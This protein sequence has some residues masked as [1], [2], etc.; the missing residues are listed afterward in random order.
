[1]NLLYLYI[2]IRIYVSIFELMKCLN[3]NQTTGI[4]T[5]KKKKN[6][7]ALAFR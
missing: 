3:K 7:K 1:M 2:N 4:L 5:L 6:R